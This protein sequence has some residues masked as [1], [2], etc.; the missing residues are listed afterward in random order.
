M[1]ALTMV[2][3]HIIATQLVVIAILGWRYNGAVT[4]GSGK[5]L[6]PLCLTIAALAFRL[7]V[8]YAFRLIFD[9]DLALQ[10]WWS[11]VVFLQA[12]A[13]AHMGNR[14]LAHYVSGWMLYR[15]AVRDAAHTPD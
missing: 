8:L 9:V 13:I 5:Y 6:G 2:V 14:V 11:I 15:R 3:Y 4:R 1:A 12:V 10:W 7:D